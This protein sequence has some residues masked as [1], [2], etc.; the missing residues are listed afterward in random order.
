MTAETL[1]RAHPLR[2][3]SGRFAAL[4]DG[5]R[6]A[7]EPFLAQA[8]LRATPFG[9]AAA[10]VAAGLGVTGL[11]GPS[12]SATGPTATVIWLGPDEW[13]V[14]TPS[15]TPGE[16]ESQLRAAA[17]P[18][19]AVVDVSAQRTAL[20]LRGRHAR[21]LLETGCAIDLHPRAFRAGSA[22]AT[23][24]GPAQVL[25]LALDGTATDYRILV[26]ASFAGYLAA[27]L[28]DAATEFRTDT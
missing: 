16:L 1:D 12:R 26:R 8:C 19:G 7:A 15:P 5:V 18:D 22:V 27:W 28:V 3:W 10:R 20:R 9:P 23:M 13:L 2:S 6:L 24:L 17:G 4:P 25:L 14:T 11:P 21:D